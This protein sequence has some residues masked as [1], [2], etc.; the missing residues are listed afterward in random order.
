VP[1]LSRRAAT[2]R[3]CASWKS[4]DIAAIERT[5]EFRVVITFSRAPS[6]HRGIGPE[7]IAKNIARVRRENIEEVI[8]DP[9]QHRG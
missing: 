5:A 4:N 2:R 1:I 3:S 7:Q 8:G 9:P 6:T